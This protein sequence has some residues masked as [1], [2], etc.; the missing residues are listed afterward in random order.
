MDIKRVLGAC[1][2]AVSL[3]AV[4]VVGAP[5]AQAASCGLDFGGQKY[6][7]CHNYKAKVGIKY[8]WGAGPGGTP[9]GSTVQYCVGAKSTKSIAR[10]DLGLAEQAIGGDQKC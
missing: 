1:A 5:G 8:V 6:T 9:T 4:S 3:V 2:A 7:N 10:P